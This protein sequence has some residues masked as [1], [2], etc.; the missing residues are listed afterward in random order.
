[1][2]ILPAT[3]GDEYGIAMAHVSAWQT[4]YRGIVA[5]GFLDALD[6]AERAV[7][8]QEVLRDRSCKLLVAKDGEHVLGFASFG[9]SR[10]ANAVSTDGEIWTMYVNPDSWRGGVGRALMKEALTSLFNEGLK[11]VFVW[12]LRANIRGI[13]F[14]SA[15][16]LTLELESARLFQL[17]GQELAEIVL[18]R[19]NAA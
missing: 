5:D 17:G 7:R 14:Y 18:V 6:V 8:W 2:N 12:V 10:E 16:G 13:A 9:R 19:R 4:G 3:A 15:C 11:T 1:M